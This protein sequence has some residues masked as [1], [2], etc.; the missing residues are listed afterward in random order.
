MVRKSNIT[1][2]NDDDYLWSG[3]SVFCKCGHHV[4]YHYT[5]ARILSVFGDNEIYRHCRF[6]HKEDEDEDCN[7]KE[8]RPFKNEN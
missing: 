2:D 5:N 1:S 8:F 6:K 4:E 7:C 3:E